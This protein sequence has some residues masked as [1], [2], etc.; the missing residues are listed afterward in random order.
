MD[1]SIYN[2]QKVIMSCQEGIDLEKNWKFK[3]CKKPH[4]WLILHEEAVKN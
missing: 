3:R 4:R 2:G 1:D